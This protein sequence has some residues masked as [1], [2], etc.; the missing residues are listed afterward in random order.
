M[1]SSIIATGTSLFDLYEDDSCFC[2]VLFYLKRHFFLIS[3]CCL[4]RYMYYLWG[5][6][7]E[8]V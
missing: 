4:P 3:T 8:S 7:N 6:S 1:V 5:A 2:V